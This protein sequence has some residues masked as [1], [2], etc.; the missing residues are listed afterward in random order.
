MSELAIVPPPSPE[1]VQRNLAART[2]EV[3]ARVLDAFARTLEPRMPKGLTL[4]AVGG[5]GR[6]EIFPYSDVDL[7]L[8]TALDTVIPPREAISEFLQLLWDAGLR[9]SHSVH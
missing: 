8:L 7:L 2:S 4:A 9:P 3:E 5:F 6:R 1:A